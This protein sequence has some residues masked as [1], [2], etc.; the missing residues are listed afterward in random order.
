MCASFSKLTPERPEFDRP[1][2]ARLRHSQG[3]RASFTYLSVPDHKV[4]RT[5]TD[6]VDAEDDGL[7]LNYVLKGEMIHDFGASEVKTVPGSVVVVDNARIFDANIGSGAVTELLVFR[8]PRDLQETASRELTQRLGKHPLLPALSRVLS[9]AT[10]RQRA[11]DDE[12]IDD[13]AAALFGLI[14]TMSRDDIG[15]AS[16]SGH[17]ATFLKARALARDGCLDADFSIEDLAL[18]L[19]LSVRTLQQHLA[20]CGTTFT[21]MLN[22]ERCDAADRLINANPGLTVAHIAERVGYRNLSTFYRS[23]RRKTGSTPRT[24]RD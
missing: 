8:I 16:F 21:E 5:R 13:T 9:H 14:R 11:W 23:Y 18:E 22:T 24:H 3:A 17:Q 2:N 7:Y 6:I 15:R 10:H 20:S 19:G 4:S 1:F 12:E